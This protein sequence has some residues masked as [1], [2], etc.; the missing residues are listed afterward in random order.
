M[1]KEILQSCADDS[2]KKTSD[3]LEVNSENIL[4]GEGGGWEVEPCCLNFLVKIDK[5][6]TG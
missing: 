6:N 1:L 5:D 4:I 3:Q 2:A